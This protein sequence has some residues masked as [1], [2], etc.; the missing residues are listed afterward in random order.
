MDGQRY[1]VLELNG[2]NQTQ[3]R[4]GWPKMDFILLRIPFCCKSVFYS[5]TVITFA[6]EL[7]L[8]RIL[9]QFVSTEKVRIGSEQ[10]FVFAI[11]R[12]VKFVPEDRVFGDLSSNVGIA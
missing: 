7:G 11:F 6:Y 3:A 1:P 2:Q 9:Y 8:R 4:V 10:Y 12:F 5:K